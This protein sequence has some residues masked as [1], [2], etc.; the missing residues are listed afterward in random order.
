MWLLL[1]VLLVAQVW[2]LYLL[3]PG[4]GEPLVPGQDKVGH[5]VIFGLPFA[6]ALLLRAWPVTLGLFVHA[7]VSEPL[8]GLLTASRIADPWDLVADLIGMVL[9]TLAVRLIVKRRDHATSHLATA[10]EGA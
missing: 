7:V 3:V 10:P 6:L 1:V 5:A 2:A 8:Q 9:A 4:V